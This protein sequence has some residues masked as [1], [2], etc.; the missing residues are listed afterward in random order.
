MNVI[1]QGS[2]LSECLTN[3]FT[4]VIDRCKNLNREETAKIF[5]RK[6]DHS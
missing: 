1:F 4:K 2:V 3:N 5:P 6:C